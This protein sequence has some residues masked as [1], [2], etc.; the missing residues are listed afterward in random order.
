[1]NFFYDFLIIII[2]EMIIALR[3]HYLGWEIGRDQ[4][5]KGHI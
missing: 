2:M 5:S 4:S 1:M 3:I